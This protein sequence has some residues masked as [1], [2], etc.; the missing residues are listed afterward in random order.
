[1]A[2]EAVIGQDA[3]QIGVVAEKDAKQIPSLA[4]E[5]IAAAEDRDG[6]R[7]GRDLISVSLDSD[8]GRVLDGEQVI[9]DFEAFGSGGEVDAA[10]VHH[11]LVLGVGVVP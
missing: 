3:P 1:M 8:A 6:G 5:P 2:L 4:L 10:D 11:L 9:D 7:D